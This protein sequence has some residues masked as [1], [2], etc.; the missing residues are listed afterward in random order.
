MKPRLFAILSVLFLIVVLAAWFAPYVDGE[1]ARWLQPHS[2]IDPAAEKIAKGEMVDCCRR[3]EGVS[4]PWLSMKDLRDLDGTLTAVRAGQAH[5]RG[6]YPR[7]YPVNEE[8]TLAT[9]FFWNN[10]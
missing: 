6:F 9:G 2:I 1:L 7:V 8:M 3:N 10:R 4:A 5:A